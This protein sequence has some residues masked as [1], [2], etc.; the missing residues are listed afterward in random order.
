[1]WGSFV[2]CW[3]V[4]VQQTVRVVD[5]PKRRLHKENLYRVAGATAVL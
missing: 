4:A 1:M 5:E 2:M 3:M